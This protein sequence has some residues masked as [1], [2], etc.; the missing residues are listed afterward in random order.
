MWEPPGEGPLAYPLQW[1]FHWDLPLGSP[2]RQSGMR[3]EF[4]TGGLAK[5][6]IAFTGMGG[7]R[8]CVATELAGDT[9]LLSEVESGTLSP[10]QLSSFLMLLCPCP[11][12]GHSPQRP[13]VPSTLL[14]SPALATWSRCL[15]LSPRVLPSHHLTSCTSYLPPKAPSRGPTSRKTSVITPSPLQI[16]MQQEDM[17]SK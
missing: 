6:Q 15:T 2:P 7:Q 8:L 9:T 14:P 12:P 11:W 5:M 3:H 16:F 17:Q 1:G 10:A 13:P 4:E